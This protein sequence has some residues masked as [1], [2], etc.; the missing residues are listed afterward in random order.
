MLALKPSLK[1]VKWFK[2][3]HERVAYVNVRKMHAEF[4][5]EYADILA[6][7]LRLSG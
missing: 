5:V 2:R 6:F 1:S 7:L 4:R 3:M